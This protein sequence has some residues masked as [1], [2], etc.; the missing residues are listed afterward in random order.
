MTE[1]EQIE[2]IRQNDREA[3]RALVAEYQEMVTR[4][5]FHFVRNLVDAEDLAQ[6]VFVEVFLSVHKF[7][8]DSSLSTWIYRIAVNK[9]LNLLRKNER[10]KTWKSIESFF[11]GKNNPVLDIPQPDKHNLEADEEK[12]V[13]YRAIERLSENQ[14]TAFTLHKFEE[15]SHKEI[16]AI[17][18]TSVSG[19]ESLIFRAKSNLQKRLW[20][21]FK[22]N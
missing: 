15:L 6:E 13:L 17:L 19:V 16:A 1:P 7:R 21:Y 20:N 10:Q 5:C 12:A 2:R 3:F 11:G 22:K 14:R 18:N 8:G 4:T 9:S